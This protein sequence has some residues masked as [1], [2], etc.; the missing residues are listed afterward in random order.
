MSDSRAGS[1]SV[2][3]SQMAADFLAYLEIVSEEYV[4]ELL[5]VDYSQD[6][7]DVVFLQVCP[8]VPSEPEIDIRESEEVRVVF[9]AADIKEPVVEVCREDFPSME[10]VNP[11]FDSQSL[12]SICL[13]AEPWQDRKLF[14]TSGEFLSRIFMW[15]QD[16]AEGKLHRDDQAVEPLFVG[17]SFKVV[18]PSKILNS[19][20]KEEDKVHKIDFREVRNEEN[21]VLVPVF[22]DREDKSSVRILS[23][24]AKEQ[25]HGQ[26]QR[27]LQ[28]FGELLA[29]LDFDFEKF[30]EILVENIHAEN[31]DESGRFMLF[32][33][34][35]NKRETEGDV[36][37]IEYRLFLFEKTLRQ[38]LEELGIFGGVEG[39][40]ESGFLIGGAKPRESDFEKLLLIPLEVLEDLNRKKA[41]FY[42]GVENPDSKILMLGSGALGSQVHLNLSRTGWG[43]WVVVDSDFLFPHNIVRHSSNQ[44]MV[45]MLK[46]EISVIQDS[47]ITSDCQTKAITCDVLNPGNRGSELKD[48]YRGVDVILDCSASVAVARHISRDVESDARRVSAFIGAGMNS[49]IFLGE[50]AARVS[51]MDWLEMQM[52]RESLLNES[53]SRAILDK[54]KSVRYGGSCRDI[55]VQLAQDVVGVMSGLASRALRRYV[56]EVRARICIYNIEDDDS[57]SCSNIT[58]TEPK[59]ETVGDWQIVWD[60]VL[61][62]NMEALRR[63]KLPNETGGILLGSRD[64]QRKIVYVVDVLPEPGDSTASEKEFIRG[65][66]NLEGD[67][68]TVRERTAGGLEYVGEW[69]SHPDGCRAIPSPIDCAALVVLRERAILADIPVLMAI[70]GESEEH[71]FA[72][73]P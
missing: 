36:E 49:L 56:S 28:N 38:V 51:Q 73:V 39:F 23:G 54:S 6:E 26:I 41:Q 52:Y 32:I 27:N 45:G 7:R 13:Y 37:R 43:E 20:L 25:V 42:G 29:L 35:P 34:F 15:L 14:W 72:I 69:H 59:S 50:D 2:P 18:L 67:L 24:I 21:S 46:S 68:K 31:H 55:S 44:S 47:W 5:S 62:E 61:I 19:L 70:V 22:G 65:V 3:K 64:T 9:D 63:E 16:A 4:Y 60:S 12:K 71:S 66:S 33:Q 53:V 57:I 58:P 30:S 8:D 10:H 1:D 48:A 11:Q 17:S 40:G